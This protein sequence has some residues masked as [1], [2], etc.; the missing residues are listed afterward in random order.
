MISDYLAKPIVKT[1]TKVFQKKYDP[2]KPTFKL[3]FHHHWDSFLAACK[4]KEIHIEDYKRYEVER[5]MA[6]GTLEM[7]GEVYECPHCHRHHIICY[8]CKSRFCNSCGAKMVRAR[9]YKIAKSTIDVN[10]RHMVFTIDERIRDYF[11]HNHEWLHFLFD[12]ASEAIFYTFN[13]TKTSSVQ[14]CKK[15]RRKRK[16]KSVI[17]PGFIITLHT[18]G[19]DLKWNPHVHVLCTEGGMNQDHV[20]KALPY[21]NY[22]SLRKSFMKQLLDK[23]RDALSD[24]PQEQRKFKNLITLMYKE[25]SEGFYVHAPPREMK[26][27]GKDQVIKYMIRYAGKPP[28][29]QSRIISYDRDNGIIRYYYE[30]H[31]TGQRIEVEEN[32]FNFIWKLLRHIPEPQ[33]KMVRYYGIYACCDHKQKKAV[34]LRL[35]KQ[36]SYKYN[37]NRPRHYRLSL[38]DTFGVDP[39]LCTCG[40]YMEFVD[41]YVPPR[42]RAGG[43]P[44]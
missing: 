38:I 28:M 4:E 39:L 27:P 30:D 10:H 40:H 36:N 33:F 2:S 35:L 42:F 9:A 22:A 19:R 13:K 25:D 44:P 11:W 31:K 41:S 37:R 20:Y 18:Y 26:K 5:M 6:C 12:A 21:I 23:M 17:T 32:V 43:E 24:N 15:K 16:K 7:G 14:S 34:T 1:A 3:I 29:A 8:T